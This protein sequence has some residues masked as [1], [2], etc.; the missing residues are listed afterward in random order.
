MLLNHYRKNLRAVVGS[1]AAPYGY[2]LSIW[3]AGATLVSVHGIPNALSAITFVVGAVLGFTFVG[4][5]A[6][7]GVPGQSDLERGHPLIWGSLHFF[8]VGLSLGAV[9]LAAYF[10]EGLIVWT[11]GGFLVT[12]IYLLVV[13][14]ESTTSYLWEHWGDE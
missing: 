9:T 1:A 13:G 6:Y 8:S 7:G 3:A 5:L 14:A 10:I 2:T 4:A 12:S 11:L